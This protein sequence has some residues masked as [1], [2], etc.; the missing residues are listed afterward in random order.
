MKDEVLKTKIG[1]RPKFDTYRFEQSL[2][3]LVGLLIDEL[4]NEL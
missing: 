1:N 3:G 2:K 4:D